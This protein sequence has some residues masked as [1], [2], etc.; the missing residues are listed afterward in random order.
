MG[1]TCEA[2]MANPELSTLITPI[3]D[4]LQIHIQDF[5]DTKELYITPLPDYHVLLGIPWHYD[6]KAMID[7]FAKPITITHR[8]KTKALKVSSKADFVP[9]VSASAMVL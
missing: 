6:H 4:K 5:V 3:I 8:G 7:T 2:N 9:L 1:P